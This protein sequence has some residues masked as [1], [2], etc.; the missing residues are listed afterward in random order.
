MR[1]HIQDH[2]PALRVFKNRIELGAGPRNAVMA[3]CAAG[4]W[5]SPEWLRANYS[6]IHDVVA[7]LEASGDLRGA[8]VFKTDHLL[9]FQQEAAALA[10]AELKRSWAETTSLEDDARQVAEQRETERLKLRAAFIAQRGAQL[11]EIHVQ[12]LRSRFEAAAADEFDAL[13]PRVVAMPAGVVSIAP[14]ATAK[15]KRQQPKN[16]PPSA[17]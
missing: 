12:K 17:A 15:P 11:Y 7:K 3:A 10:L 16:E 4:A 6:P 14:T 13:H 2:P 8:V 9:E 1:P 5:P